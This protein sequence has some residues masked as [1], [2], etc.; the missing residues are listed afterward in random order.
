[1][2]AAGE[3]LGRLDSR[4]RYMAEYNYVC[5]HNKSSNVQIKLKEKRKKKQN[6]AVKIIFKKLKRHFKITHK[7]VNVNFKTVVARI[8]RGIRKRISFLPLLVFYYSSSN[9]Q[10]VSQIELKKGN[11]PAKRLFF[12]KLKKKLFS[13]RPI[14]MRTRQNWT[15]LG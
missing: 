3:G 4:N 2:I 12:Q 14:R 11:N 6:E 9:L 15:A 13:G 7:E 8:S 5:L 1:M 10:K